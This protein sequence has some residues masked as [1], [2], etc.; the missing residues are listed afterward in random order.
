MRD[1]AFTSTG[2]FVSGGELTHWQSEYEMRREHANRRGRGGP[3]RPSSPSVGKGRAGSGYSFTRRRRNRRG[4]HR[5]GLYAHR[6]RESD[7]HPR[8]STA[9]DASPSVGLRWLYEI[10]SYK[11]VE[12]GIRVPQ[13]DP[14]SPSQQCSR[15]DCGS[16]LE[17]IR[18]GEA[19][20]CL[21]CGYKGTRRLQRREE[22]GGKGRQEPPPVAHVGRRS[23]DP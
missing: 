22:R 4:C 7:R 17:V 16:T 18:N 15:T 23:G 19:Y 8:T 9:G 2:L 10:V 1:R 21:K 12:A 3:T 13:M 6:V 14:R 5:P 11:A 20:H